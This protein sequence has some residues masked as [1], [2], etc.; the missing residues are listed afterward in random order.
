M[1]TGPQLPAALGWASGKPALLFLHLMDLLF[2]ISTQDSSIID[3]NS[4]QQILTARHGAGCWESSEQGTI[5][6]HTV[7]FQPQ[8]SSE[9]P[10]GHPYPMPSLWGPGTPCSFSHPLAQTFLKSRATPWKL[11]GPWNDSELTIIMPSKVFLLVSEQLPRTLQDMI[12][13]FSEGCLHQ[14]SL[15]LSQ[16]A[17]PMKNLSQFVI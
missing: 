1:L 8:L 11:P 4:I 17:P 16:P 10:S 13:C 14:S 7:T 15:F 3:L 6:L 2:C 9:R 12:Y 5:D